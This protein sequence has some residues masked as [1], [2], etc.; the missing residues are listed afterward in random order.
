MVAFWCVPFNVHDI[1]FRSAALWNLRRGYEA[2]HRVQNT[3]ELR[4]SGMWP[5]PTK[6][7]YLAYV[8][9]NRSQKERHRLEI[10]QKCLWHMLSSQVYIKKSTNMVIRGDYSF[11]SV[12]SLTS[13]VIYIDDRHIVQ[14]WGE[15]PWASH[16]DCESEGVGELMSVQ[17]QGLTNRVSELP[18]KGLEEEQYEIHTSTTIQ[19]NNYALIYLL[20]SLRTYFFFFLLLDIKLQVHFLL[21]TWHLI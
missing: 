10:R 19:M 21:A 15:G 17:E 12:C 8:C 16:R 3:L 11:P 18:P 2:V 1:T 14:V 13:D 6:K 5:S 7:H 4:C 20:F 9:L